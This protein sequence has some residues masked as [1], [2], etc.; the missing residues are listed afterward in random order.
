MFP[1]RLGKFLGGGEANNGRLMDA[2]VLLSEK[3]GKVLGRGEANNGRLMDAV[4]LLSK[5]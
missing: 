5:M 3:V 1:E 4:V 2:V